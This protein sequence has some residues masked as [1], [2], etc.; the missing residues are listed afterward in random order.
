MAFCLVDGSIL[1]V[2][3]DPPLKR[4]VSNDAQSSPD[5]TLILPES[6]STPETDLLAPTIPA[7]QFSEF[8]PQHESKPQRAASKRRIYVPVVVAL[9]AL[10]LIIGGGLLLFGRGESQGP[11]TSSPG[12]TAGSTTGESTPSAIFGS[13]G[14]TATQSE[15]GVE[16]S[17][18]A[19]IP[20]R[21]ESPAA[22][23]PVITQNEKLA[24]YEAVA[25]K[26]KSVLEAAENAL[27]EQEK[28]VKAAKAD[29]DR[30]NANLQVADREL[31]RAQRLM[32]AKI[33]SQGEFNGIKSR[34][35]AS[36]K[37]QANAHNLY[38]QVQASYRRAKEGYDE[39]QRN[40]L[41]AQKAL[42]DLK[43][44]MNN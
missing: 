17:T 15:S 10:S 41:N 2:P 33:L 19:E 28:K 30:E 14:G 16:K 20:S 1:S 31:K 42:R 23:Q 18:T 43:A 13:A 11:T 9:G 21:T 22:S 37:Q 8:K 35:S 40:F 36:Q 7:V 24:R 44:G 34:Y 39:A 38:A 27:Q 4:P 6:A 5:A 32:D 29:L 3:Y 25:M 26:A 12:S